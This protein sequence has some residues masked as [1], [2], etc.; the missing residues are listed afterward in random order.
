MFSRAARAYSRVTNTFTPPIRGSI[1][2]TVSPMQGFAQAMIRAGFSNISGLP[3]TPQTFRVSFFE[4]SKDGVPKKCSDGQKIQSK[5][6]APIIKVMEETLQGKFENYDVTRTFREPRKNREILVTVKDGELAIA[7]DLCNLDNGDRFRTGPWEGTCEN[8]NGNEVSFREFIEGKKHSDSGFAKFKPDID[9]PGRSF[10]GNNFKFMTQNTN[11][12]TLLGMCYFGEFKNENP[13]NYQKI[14]PEL[15]KQIK[16]TV[17][18]MEDHNSDTLYTM[19]AVPAEAPKGQEGD[20]VYSLQPYMSELLKVFGGGAENDEMN[21]LDTLVR[22]KELD[23]DRRGHSLRWGTVSFSRR[24]L[25]KSVQQLERRVLDHLI[26][27]IQ[28][29][30]PRNTKITKD[31][32]A[33]TKSQPDAQ[34]TQLSIEQRA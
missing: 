11:R 1:Q 23:E 31:T 34:H 15:I 19:V 3:K 18:Y 2:P 24:S 21:V 27:K 22:Y 33:L 28:K 29:E 16:E 32:Q 30:S 4:E 10:D 20:D 9:L 26:T 25:E 5:Q 13:G 17:R 6:A 7:F 8:E 12:S 14:V